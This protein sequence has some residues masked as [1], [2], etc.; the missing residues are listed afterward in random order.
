M[1]KDL[2]RKPLRG[3]IVEYDGKDYFYQP[4]G[5]A[6]YLYTDRKDIGNIEKSVRSP[7]SAKV[8]L[9]KS[10]DFVDTPDEDNIKLGKKIPTRIH[11]TFLSYF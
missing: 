9:I 2:K 1:E 5:N 10:G 4:L 8:T 6:C 11:S 3:D 7:N